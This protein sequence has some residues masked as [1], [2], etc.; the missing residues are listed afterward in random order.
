MRCNVTH[1][2]YINLEKLCKSSVAMIILS[3]FSKFTLKHFFVNLI[4]HLSKGQS[5]HHFQELTRHGLFDDYVLFL[6]PIYKISNIDV[7]MHVIM[8]L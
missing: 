6:L 1:F 8:T 7:Y 2:S 3:R 4:C 5:F